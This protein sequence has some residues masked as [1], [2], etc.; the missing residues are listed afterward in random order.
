MPNPPENRLTPFLRRY[1]EAMGS[2]DLN[3]QEDVHMG[4]E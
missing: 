3:W 1:M 2:D 4:Y